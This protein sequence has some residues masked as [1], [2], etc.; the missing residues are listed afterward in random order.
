MTRAKQSPFGSGRTGR[1]PF[2]ILSFGNGS[3]RPFLLIAISAIAAMVV[4]LPEV[5]G[6][7]EVESTDGR[8]PAGIRTTFDPGTAS[9]NV[10]WPGRISQYDLVYLS[11]PIDPLQGIPLGN[12][13]VGVL[14]W[15]EDSKIIAVVNKSDLW[16]DA[17]LGR[18]HNWKT[19][20]E[21]T[22]TTQ[23]HACRI[24]IDF[25]NPVFNTLYLSDFAARLNLADAS[26]TLD[27]RSPFGAVR[28][29]AFVDH[30]SGVLFCELGT[31]CSEDVPVD[32]SVERFG[33]RTFSHWYSLINR[34]ASVGLSGT[35]AGAGPDCAWITQALSGGKFAAG[36][37]VISDN[38]LTVSLSREHSRR[39]VISLRGS[40][41]KEARLAFAVTSPETDDPVS[42]LKKTLGTVREKGVEAFRKSHEEAWKSLWLRSFW[43]MGTIT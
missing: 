8:T 33:S 13:D 4:S 26:L 6:S 35:D 30:E 43:T 7:A 1:G 38:G 12:G 9:W 32:I 37:S 34:D 25:R 20:E 36:G 27:A 41:R 24:V 11:P 18:F 23:R 2:S 28:L 17:A 31:D 16:D 21:D 42:G 5:A 14:F 19:E 10:D 29:R 40:R 39:S 15:C 3:A 22:S